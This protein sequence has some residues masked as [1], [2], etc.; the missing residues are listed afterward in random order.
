M[1]FLGAL[2]YVST[3]DREVL[4]ITE[5]AKRLGDIRLAEDE[6][7]KIFFQTSFL[8][9]KR[10]AQ[11]TGFENKSASS[12]NALDDLKK[13]SEKSAGSQGIS[14]ELKEENAKQ[15]DEMRKR[16]ELS[17]NLQLQVKVMNALIRQHFHAHNSRRFFPM[18][19]DI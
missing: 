6:S 11:Y 9:G 19:E 14:A 8:A 15:A 2:E 13:E 16:K 12:L 1:K 7:K 18:K 17:D 10:W 4:L 5:R 3:L